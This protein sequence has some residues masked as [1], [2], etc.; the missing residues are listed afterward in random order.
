M[1]KYLLE[2]LK[3]VNT[4]IIPGLGA[5]TITDPEKGDIMFMPYLKHDDGELSKYIA[6]KEGI[7]LND[8]VNLIAKYVREILN[9]LDK[10]E[11]Y[12]MFQ[13]GSFVKNESGDIEFKVWNTNAASAEVSEETPSVHEESNETTD[14][15]EGTAVSADTN[16]ESQEQEIEPTLNIREPEEEEITEAID[17]T[18]VQEEI[19]VSEPVIEQEPTVQVEEEKES[20]REFNI[21]EKEEQAAT[22]ARLD[23]LREEKNKP[24]K[25]RRGAGFYALI[26]FGIIIV[27]FSSY[28]IIDFEGASKLMP[29]L[30]SEEAETAEEQNL[31]E[32]MEEIL[33]EAQPVAEETEDTSN[34]AEPETQEVSEEPV[35]VEPEII[36]QPEP[37]K[38]KEESA[39]V[40]TSSESGYH[41]IAGSFG[42]PDNAERFAE[43]LRNE[44]APAKLIME[45]GLHKVSLGSYAT[46]A[47]AKE[48]L[49]N[50]NI[51]VEAF[52]HKVD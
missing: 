41:I 16:Q 5:L 28:V 46:R 40:P 1:D 34:I 33:G 47:E 49:N 50:L 52:I 36:E 38:K 4:I 7:E 18:P 17:E 21:L 25:K 26:I 24:R 31:L 22:Q 3:E 13:F 14:K 45:N 2:I 30:A 6:N 37:I 9:T 20:P 39:P 8:A 11:S 19:E 48:A 42:N 44:G 12:D 29:F 23:K 43:K 35:Q 27:S 15:E 10:G 32:E 51:S